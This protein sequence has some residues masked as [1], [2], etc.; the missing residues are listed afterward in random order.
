M[1]LELRI[2]EVE[3]GFR[4][5]WLDFLKAEDLGRFLSFRDDATF[6]LFRELHGGTP[7][8]DPADG[9]P[10]ELRKLTV[11]R[12]GVAEGSTIVSPDGFARIA[13]SPVVEI[14][15]YRIV[16]GQR[17]RFAAF[18]RDRAIPAQTRYGIPVYGQF[19]DLDDETCFVWMRGFPDLAVREQRKAHLY[20]GR[21][22]LEEMEAE[23]FSMIE[24]YSNSILAMPVGRGPWLEG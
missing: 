13:E 12:L 4:C 22:W 1:Q 5:N 15:Q 20:Q 8:S 11:R 6:A 21:L 14:R 19:D 9:A 2:Y 24:D 7:S 17:G 16:P 10:S 3:P 18:F 23:A